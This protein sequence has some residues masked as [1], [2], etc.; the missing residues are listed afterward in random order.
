MLKKGDKVRFRIIV[1]NIV[2][3]MILNGI[4]LFILS[5]IF[6]DEINFCFYFF[7]GNDYF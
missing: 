2:F 7:V 5:Y 3:F 6:V 4:L 1:G